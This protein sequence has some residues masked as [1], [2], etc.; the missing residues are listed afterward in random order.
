M[1]T[2]RWVVKFAASDPARFDSEAHIPVFHRWI[3]QKT[4][5]VVL[6]DVADYAHVPD[7]PGVLLVS[8]E[9]NIFADHFDG[10]PGLTV[11]RKARGGAGAESLVDTLRTGLQAID[12]LSSEPSLPGS[13]FRLDGIEIVAN[14]RLRGPNTDDGWKAAEPALR[15]AARR[16]FG[17]DAT[18]ERIETAP[19][20]R[21]TGRIAGAAAGSASGDAGNAKELLERLG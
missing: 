10:T 14:D 21:L 6:I 20:S 5:P 13:K 4:L 1:S 3:Q 11:Q 15:V 18:V 12:A 19:K 9:Y 16:L 17:D 2:D 8:H 7:G